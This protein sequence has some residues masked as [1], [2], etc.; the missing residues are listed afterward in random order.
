LTERKRA[1]AHCATGSVSLH[2]LS[3][4]FPV[5][6]R[7]LTPEGEPIFFNK[8][9]LDF[10]GLGDLSDLDKPGMSRLAATIPTLVHTDDATS[11]LETSRRSFA[12]G[13]PFSMKYRMRRATAHIGGLIPARNR[14]EIESGAI[15]QWYVISLDIDDEMRAQEV[16]RQSEWRLGS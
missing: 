4:C 10:F 3:T 13:E 16:L 7:R 9:L 11:L 5:Y 1:E 12:A 6:I 14:C 8:R 15:V 2:S